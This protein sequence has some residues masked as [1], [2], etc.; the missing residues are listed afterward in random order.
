MP[1]ARTG[2]II[3][4]DGVLYA[5]V[6]YKDIDGKTRTIERRARNI[7]EARELLPS[8]LAEAE[9]REEQPVDAD[10]LTFRV[11]TIIYEAERVVPAVYVGNRKVAG[12]RAHVSAKSEVKALTDYFGDRLVR[13]ITYAD[14]ERFKRNLLAT[15]TK[16]DK[17]R[18]IMGLNH[19]L[20][21]LRT[22][23]NFAIQRRWITANPFRFG[24]LLVN[25]ADEIPRNRP[26]QEGEEERLLAQ[27]VGRRAH[28]RP[29]I[30]I[31]LDTAMRR[32]EILE[33]RRSDVDLFRGT[34]TVRSMTTKTQTE[35]IVPI[36]KRLAVKLRQWLSNLP[37]DPETL[38]F[39]GIKSLKTSFASACVDAKITGL[40]FHDL[41]HWATTDPVNAL[42]AAGLAPQHAMKITGHT[43]EKT[44]R[45]YL[46]TDDELVDSAREALDAL[47]V[48]QEKKRRKKKLKKVG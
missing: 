5:R 19:L 24:P 31:A 17:Q 43:Q 37:M 12:M 30:I 16:D 34:I 41:R 22:I 39:G 15:P 4:R 3:E 42:A 11:L 1:R 2:A 44:F 6:R 9:K 47:R 27:C 26:R 18:T 8:L 21:R 10:R 29:I 36:S 7:T 23:L 40:H 33:L 14:L 45:R 28:L 46:R 48:A 32:G 38:L 25:A 20:R 13:S 35:R